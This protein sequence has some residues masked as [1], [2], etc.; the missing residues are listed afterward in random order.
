MCIAHR[1]TT[2]EAVD[3]LQS[4]GFRDVAPI[5]ENGLTGADLLEVSEQ[6]LRDELGLSHFQVMFSP[7]LL[8]DCS[9]AVLGDFT[10]AC[11]MTLCSV[12]SW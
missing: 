11:H 6:E 5:E 12:L 3:L 9:Q 10:Q 1:Y 8:A 7:A 4:V 2:E